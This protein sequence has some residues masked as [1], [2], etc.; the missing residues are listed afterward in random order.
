VKPDECRASHSSSCIP[1][2]LD[3]K[4]LLGKFQP[5]ACARSI[6]LKQCISLPKPLWHEVMELC[7]GELE[8]VSSLELL[9]RDDILM[10]D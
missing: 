1:G 6:V 5:V 3:V 4:V 7:G 8:E 10:E 2:E 9:K